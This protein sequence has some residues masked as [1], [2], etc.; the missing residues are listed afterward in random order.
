MVFG[1]NFHYMAPFGI[2][3]PGFCM[4][5]QPASFAFHARGETFE[6][7]DQILDPQVDILARGPFWGQKWVPKKVFLRRNH[8]VVAIQGISQDPNE[9]YGP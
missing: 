4:V 2:P 3:R 8:V 5:F 9:F 6:H 1:H 7:G